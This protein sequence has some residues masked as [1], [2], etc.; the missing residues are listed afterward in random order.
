VVTIKEKNILK[1]SLNPV[2][3]TIPAYVLNK[4]KIIECIATTTN[5][6]LEISENLIL[7]KSTPI[8][9]NKEI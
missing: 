2:Y 6:T 3:R 5:E 8:A 9:I 4:I 7:K 1:A